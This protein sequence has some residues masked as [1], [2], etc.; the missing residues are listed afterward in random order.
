M[1][2]CMY[3]WVHPE[4]PAEPIAGLKGVGDD[5]IAIRTAAFVLFFQL[6]IFFVLEKEN[7]GHSI[8]I[9]DKSVTQQLR[10][11]YINSLFIRVS[12]FFFPGWTSR[13]GPDSKE[14]RH[15]CSGSLLRRNTA[16][17]Q[18]TAVWLAAVVTV[19]ISPAI[20]IRNRGWWSSTET[21]GDSVSSWPETIPS[22]SKLFAKVGDKIPFIIPPFSA[23]VVSCWRCYLWHILSFCL[24]L[25][26]LL[27]FLFFYF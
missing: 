21:I 6:V 16:R 22:L 10:D 19:V 13:T 20:L 23:G 11:Y 8:F 2:W 4:T 1:A 17:R 5:V 27:F 15:S 9:W 14:V 7:V 3:M 18:S 25:C 26:L 24:S 12:S